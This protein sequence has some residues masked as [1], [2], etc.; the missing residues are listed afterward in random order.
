MNELGVAKGWVKKDADPVNNVPLGAP[1]KFTIK[2]KHDKPQSQADAFD[3]FVTDILPKN[4]RYVQCS[5]KYSGW[6]PTTPE[7]DYCNLGT[8]TT[9][10]I[11]FW[12]VFPLDET[13]TITFD[14]VLRGSPATNTVS[15]EWTSLN[16]ELDIDGLP[17]RLSTHNE[18]S[19]ERWYDP[20]NGVDVYSVADSVTINP[21][22]EPAED[23]AQAMP[24]ELPGTG[25]APN[26]VTLLS[27][28]PLEKS[29]AETEVWVE[30][31][32]LG[33]KIPIVGVPLVDNNWDVSWLWRD[34]G[35]LND[36]VFPSW[37]GNSA[38]TAMWSCQMAPRTICATWGSA[39]GRQGRRLCVW[40]HLYV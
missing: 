35:W 33:A 7:S 27:E 18:T 15:V 16:I 9:D 31:P 29:Y 3:V 22:E 24:R 12:D 11:F 1:V 13:S 26:Q 23:T 28:Q 25:F 2:I 17:V 34:A 21:T 19:H 36:T 32:R 38:L 6:S 10:L 37:K 20:P 8:N 30:I 5:V 39:L 4:L 14:A 40:F